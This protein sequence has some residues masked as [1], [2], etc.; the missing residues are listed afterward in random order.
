MPP[1]QTK[2]CW[3]RVKDG[4][5]TRLFDVVLFLSFC[6]SSSVWLIFFFFWSDTAEGREEYGG[7][8][9]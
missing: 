6:F 9:R 2:R 8:G 4:G 7:T 1:G 3:S 5:A